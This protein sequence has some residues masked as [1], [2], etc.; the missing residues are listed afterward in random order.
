VKH[1]FDIERTVRTYALYF[2]EHGDVLREL[3]G[4][5]SRSLDRLVPP[6]VSRRV[7]Q[8]GA[9][10][11]Q[12]GAAL[13]VERHPALEAA[14]RELAGLGLFRIFAPADVGGEALPLAIY[15]LTV[16]LVSYYDT[17]LALVF[18]VHG[19]AMYVIDRYGSPAQRRR[20]L[21]AL[22]SGEQLA[23]V[24]FTEP[25]A[26][27][28]A[29]SIR[30]R[31]RRVG[32]SWRISGDKLFI[33][34]GGD[35]DLLVTTARTGRQEDAIHGV[36]AFIVEREPDGVEVLGLEDKTGLAGSPTAALSYP[37]ITIPEDRLLGELGRGG[38]VMFAGV[39]MTR[40]NIGAQALGIAKR[41]YDAAADFALERVQ[42][43]GRIVE[44]DAIQQ[45]LA[46]M[47][48]I[49]SSME[50]LIC[51]ASS[52]EHAGAWHVR[53]I[54]TTKYYCSE[55]L[56]ELTLRAVN[57]F[58][59]YGVSRDH[60]VER[61]R[62]EALALPL[63]GGTSEI[64]WLI[65]SRELLETVA[66]R[67]RVDY[68]QRDAALDRALVERCGGGGIDALEEHKELAQRTARVSATLWRA[69]ER[70][71]ERAAQEDATPHHRH[72]AELATSLAA[73]RVLIWQATGPAAG[74]LERELAQIAVDRLED[75]AV[76]TR[77]RVD[78]GC[79]R[80]GLKRAV[81]ALLD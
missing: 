62:R 16:Q 32:D 68:R 30:T 77:A 67:A 61:C 66:G 76:V 41:A 71:A 21:P 65:I 25:T 51:R 13:R 63:Y 72:L 59:G 4:S 37:G 6:E 35:A 55:A 69:V 15:Y 80:S 60:V 43:G 7:D 53:E 64:Q 9:R 81:R 8:E 42:G 2:D 46:E 52:L 18:L 23:T 36:S 44:H 22:T 47:T 29:G 33:T 56:Q 58:G 24:A 20:Y 78:S 40:V 26:G 50:N 17:S 74:E 14:R 57:V 1:I 73:T 79:T 12:D 27:S 28:D 45:R 34:N 75:R 19:N 10:L 54:S 70:V 38:E 3:L 5:V 48:L 11:V 39:G 31:A 49:I